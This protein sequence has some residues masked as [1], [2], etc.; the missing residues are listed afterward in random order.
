MV[1]VFEETSSPRRLIQRLLKEMPKEGYGQSRRLAEALGVHTT[2]VSQILGGQKQFS[3]EQAIGVCEFF[4][5]GEL[6][7]DYFLLLVQLDRAGTPSLKKTL[8]RQMEV[9]RKKAQDL[10]N[11]LSAKGGL[12]EVDRGLFYSHWKFSAVRQLSAIAE[13]QSIEAMA[14]RLRLSRRDVKE[15]LEFLIACEMV[16]ES[17]GKIS[18]GPSSTHLSS[19]SPWVRMHHLN[20]R[21]RAQQTQQY[22]NENDLTYTAPMT[23]SRKDFELIREEIILLLERVDNIL[24]PSPSEELF[25]LNIDWFRV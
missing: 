25:C 15:T 17:K 21:Q 20:W 5:F 18:I 6:E 9:L 13:Y 22:S 10:S 3:S 1:S 4:G 8:Q 19:D 16:V 2:L 11:R 24:E 12:S 14:E 7:T 23:L